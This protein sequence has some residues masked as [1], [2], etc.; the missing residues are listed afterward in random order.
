[1][2]MPPSLRWHPAD[3]LDFESLLASD[4]DRAEDALRTRDREI[5]ARIAEAEKVDRRNVFHRWLE[6]RREQEKTGLPG[7]TARTGWEALIAIA[8]VAGLALGAGVCATV[9]QYPRGEPVNVAVFLGAILGPQFVLP[10]LFGACW[11]LLRWRIG[12]PALSP[13]L[14]W[15]GGKLRRLPG[16]QR[17]RVQT[18]L[19]TVERRQEIYGSL[20]K[21]P[22]LIATQVLAVAFNVGA[23]AALLAHVPTREL[24][25]GWQTTLE[26]SSAQVAPLVALVAAPWRWAPKAHPTTEQIVATRFAPGQ[27]LA[28]LPGEAARAWWPFL[29]YAVGCYGMLLRAAVLCLAWW[30]LR[31]GLAALRF[32]HAA[33]NALWRRLTGPLVAAP[34]ATAAL[35]IPAASASMAPHAPA[36]GAVWML[37][38]QEAAVSDGDLTAAAERA[39]GWRTARTHRVK[40]DNRRDA[41]PLLEALAAE[42]MRPAAVVVAVPA[43]RDPIMAVALFLR[44]VLRVAEKA[45]VLV[46]LTSATGEAADRCKYWRDFLAL[47]RLPIGVA[48]AP[49]P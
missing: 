29:A 35:E 31:A 3:L 9:L 4:T 2:L 17:T 8:V 15:L 40:I 26:V 42:T 36:G 22:T 12:S 48:L 18:A 6:A 39:H 24:R 10:L 34:G 14:C 13:A 28:T 5:F 41:A 23:I 21:W 25:F 16:E 30:R 37:V 49:A 32:D 11:L 47:Q 46:W 43:E 45:E 27:S 20:G 38:A 19:A 33:A 7:E 44:E 1:M